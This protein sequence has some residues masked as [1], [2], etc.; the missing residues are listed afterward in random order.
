MAN[1]NLVIVLFSYSI[2]HIKMHSSEHVKATL[3]REH[4]KVQVAF[5]TAPA[6]AD[7]EKGPRLMSWLGPFIGRIWFR[8]AHLLKELSQASNFSLFS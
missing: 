7:W 4:F 1:W 2:F 5:A 6:I 3:H 8:S